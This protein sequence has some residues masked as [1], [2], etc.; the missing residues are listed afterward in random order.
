MLLL[1]VFCC[2]SASFRFVCISNQNGDRFGEDGAWAKIGKNS[3]QWNFTSPQ[4]PEAVC[5][6]VC[7]TPFAFRSK[8]R[9]RARLDR[10]FLAPLLPPILHSLSLSLGS[11]TRRCFGPSPVCVCVVVSSPHL[12]SP[13]SQR[14]CM[15]SL[16]KF[17]FLRQF[18]FEIFPSFYTRFCNFPLLCVLW[19]GVVRRRG[20]ELKKTGAAKMRYESAALC[21][22]GGEE[23]RR[24]KNSM[25][26]ALLPCPPLRALP[27]HIG[28]IS[29]IARSASC[30]PCQLTANSVMSVVAN[31]AA[32]DTDTDTDADTHM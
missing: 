18:S 6:C 28:Y 25:R 26:Y 20:E 1:V 4:V 29:Y 9:Q 2:F 27:G 24:K 22:K 7:G 23:Y 3:P 21:V 30:C 17:Q 11:V 32:A 15:G 12:S 31:C 19:C 8:Y 14:P 10:Q 5:V 16:I 13:H